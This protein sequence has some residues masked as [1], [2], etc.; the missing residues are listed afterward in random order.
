VAKKR[1]SLSQTLFSGIDPFGQ[2]T[3]GE[4]GGR[5][6]LLPVTAVQ[7]DPDQPRR[8]LPADLEAQLRQTRPYDPLTI[9][10][11]WLEREPEGDQ[12][13]ADL[14]QLADSIAQHG[15]INPITVR[16]SPT[17]AENGV[18]YWIITGERRYWSHLLLL[19]EGRRLAIGEG[20]PQQIQA[21][22]AAE[23]VSIRAHQLIENI[24]REDINA[25][26]KAQGLL[27]LR[28]ELSG[29]G[30]QVNDSS[31]VET[32]VN[33]SSP[34]LVPWTQVSETLGISPRYRIYL[35]GVLELDPEAQAIIAAHN[36]AEMTIRPIVQKL[37]ERPDLQVEALQQLV[38]WQRENE[39][40]DGPNRPITKLAQDLVNR[41][42]AREKKEGGAAVYRPAAHTRKLRQTCRRALHFLHDLPDDERVLVARDLALD[43]QFKPALAE[44]EALQEQVND[45]LE[46]VKRYQK[47]G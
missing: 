25:L 30:A 41:L 7:T 1:T 5:L 19:A 4:N 14:R 29:Q 46:Q 42:L 36:L 38:A 8:L 35:T 45:L 3:P 23:G 22:L 9:M 6:L 28:R 27:A 32:E 17:P 44:L 12:R 34:Q 24:N 47:E 11:Q 21:L 43:K 26:E 37:K 33:D 31:L 10:R 2:D 16:P 13:L 18:Q 39:A 20:D 40:E 15:L